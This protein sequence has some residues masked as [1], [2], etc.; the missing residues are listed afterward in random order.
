[1]FTWVIDLRENQV[2]LLDDGEQPKYFSKSSNFI[3]SCIDP[4]KYQ[5]KIWPNAYM[6]TIE[7]FCESYRDRETVFRRTTLRG[8]IFA[9]TYF[10]ETIFSRN[11][12][13]F[14]GLI[15]ANLPVFYR[16][17]FIFLGHLGKKPYISRIKRFLKFSR[18]LIFA[19]LRKNSRTSRNIIPT[20]INPLNVLQSFVIA[21]MLRMCTEKS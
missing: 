9:G 21:L 10:R 2:G 16:I 3:S 13:I 18:G 17:S 12:L 15:F 4:W 19:N 1:M 11:N 20:K 8:L 7:E 5:G 6:V 14:A